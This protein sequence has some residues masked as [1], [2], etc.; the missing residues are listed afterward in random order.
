MTSLMHRNG[1]GR[2][3]TT[4]LGRV[5]RAAHGGAGPDAPRH[6]EEHRKV[7]WLRDV[8]LGGQDGLVNILGIV[9][10]VIAGG[11]SKMVLLAAG[12][13]AAIT[14]SISMGAVGYTSSVSERDYYQAEQAREAAEIDATP[15]AERQEI[16]DIY[17]T[18]G[19]A[20]DLLDRSS[21]PSPP[22]A[23]AGWPR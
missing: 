21:I 6:R 23:T 17:A 18:K 4:R 10:G 16:R 8:I 19:F 14:E 3:A 12:F 11:G 1:E 15:E 5:V 2:A 13:A 9:L 22:T 20:G 7:N